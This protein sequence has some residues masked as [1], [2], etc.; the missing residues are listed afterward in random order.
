DVLETDRR[1]GAAD[2]VGRYAA[3]VGGRDNGAGADARDAVERDAVAVE[4]PQHAGV[5]DAAS[6]TSAECQSD[7]RRDH[8]QGTLGI[9][10]LL[11]S[12]GAIL[13]PA[14]DDATRTFRGNRLILR[15]EIE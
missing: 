11:Q 4:R 7:P 15:S 6:E 13:A 12:A 14:P 3:G 10:D 5:G 1:S 2:V 9:S 8:R